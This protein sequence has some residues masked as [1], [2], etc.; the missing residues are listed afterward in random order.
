MQVDAAAGSSDDRPTAAPAAKA[1]K[2]KAKAKAKAAAA[3]E[4]ASEITNCPD[5][6]KAVKGKRGLTS[7]KRRCKG[8]AQEQGAASEGSKKRRRRHR[9]TPADDEAAADVKDAAAD[10]EVAADEK[11][12]A[13]DDEAAAA[14]K[15]AAADGQAAA[16]EKSASEDD[17]VQQLCAVMDGEDPNFA[18]AMEV[19]AEVAPGTASTTSSTSGASSSTT[20]STSSTSSTTSSS[21]VEAE[22]KVSIGFP[23][24]YTVEGL[25]A[26][27]LAKKAK[28]SPPLTPP[29]TRVLEE[30]LRQLVAELAERD[31]LL[32]TLPDMVTAVADRLGLPIDAVEPRRGDVEATVSYLV[33]VRQTNA[34]LAAA[35]AGP[36]KS[37]PA[38]APEL[39]PAPAPAPELAPAPAPAPA[40]DTV[41]VNGLGPA[42]YQKMVQNIPWPTL[43]LAMQHN[44]LQICQ[45]VK[46]GKVLETFLVQ[47]LEA[48]MMATEDEPRAPNLSRLSGG[49][50]SVLCGELKVS[51]PA[52][53]TKA[54]VDEAR[55]R[56]KELPGQGP[57]E[58]CKK[59]HQQAWKDLIWLGQREVLGMGSVVMYG[60][61]LQAPVV[62]L[63]PEVNI[64]LGVGQWSRELTYVTVDYKYLQPKQIGAVLVKTQWPLRTLPA[65]VYQG[66]LSPWYLT[67]QEM[68]QQAAAW[69]IS[70]KAADGHARVRQLV[71][72]KAIAEYEQQ[73]SAAVEAAWQ[74]AIEK[75]SDLTA[76]SLASNGIEAKE[77][78]EATVENDDKATHTSMDA[79]AQQV[80]L[81]ST[82]LP[83]VDVVA[84]QVQLLST[85]QP[86]QEPTSPLDKSTQETVVTPSEAAPDAQ[87]VQLPPTRQLVQDPDNGTQDAMV[88]ALNETVPAERQVQLLTTVQL[89]QDPSSEDQATADKAPIAD[90]R[91]QVPTQQQTHWSTLENPALALMQQKPRCVRCNMRTVDGQCIYPECKDTVQ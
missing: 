9:K 46:G 6:D 24:P 23:G 1:P 73:H 32:K 66:P 16:D 21:S 40:D 26:E 87:R 45:A 35:E 86:V 74:T 80:Q 79:D 7:H 90:D 4:D 58:L 53:F 52:S 31:P 28:L 61:S 82:Q 44:V 34:V 14:V 39:A 76:P 13:A 2:A 85:Q 54:H 69:G 60:K 75:P 78:L 50:V 62:L 22:P 77:A 89:V 81:L 17:V 10:G 68:L 70:A 59:L 63:R 25:L 33:G 42:I 27:A 11:D 84:Q 51:P 37:M 30:T 47:Y 48:M 64:N 43:S 3:P 12:A 91:V 8:P 57:F 15:D 88:A 55:A 67:N 49:A 36:P 5:C 56:L 72:A 20:S 29:T 41:A 19:D 83:A 65:F 71:M 18:V 38:P